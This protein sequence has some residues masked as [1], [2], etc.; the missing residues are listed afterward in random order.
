M[1]LCVG[2]IMQGEL[3]LAVF[4][5]VGYARLGEPDQSQ[6]ARATPRPVICINVIFQDTWG[7][8]TIGGH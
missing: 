3:A 4:A 7:S 6:S 8:N 1:L 2:S 5:Q